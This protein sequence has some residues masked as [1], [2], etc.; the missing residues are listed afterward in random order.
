MEIQRLSLQNFRQFR[1]ADIEFSRNPEKNVTVIHGDNGSGKTTILNAFLWVLFDELQSIKR[2]DRVA[3]QGEMVAADEGDTVAVSVEL[4]FEHE[5]L[6]HEVR[7]RKVY[8]KQSP[9]DLEGIE[10]KDS[11]TVEY[12]TEAGNVEEPTNPES[13]IRQIVPKDLAGLFFFD[14]EYISDLSNVDNQEEIQKA[15]RQMMG[16]TIMERSITHLEWVEGQFRN[17]LQD[18]GSE[19]LQ[20]LISERNEIEDKKEKLERKLGDANRKKGKL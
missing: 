19:E 15:I 6:R 11:F 16:L 1:D 20:T 10:V 5:D 3:H 12:L 14:G 9:N 7:R 4:I 8:Q 18:L 17:E 13:Y 2:P